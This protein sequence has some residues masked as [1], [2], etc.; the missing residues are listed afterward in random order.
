MLNDMIFENH[1]TFVPDRLITDNIL[2][3]AKV[4]HFLR[5]K[6][7]GNAGWVILKLDMAKAYDQME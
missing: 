2:V 6:Q 5:Q 4:G 1:S 7:W 3:A